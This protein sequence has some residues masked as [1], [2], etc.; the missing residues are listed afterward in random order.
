M[1]VVKCLNVDTVLKFVIIDNEGLLR[2]YRN[3]LFIG[4]WCWKI[5]VCPNSVLISQADSSVLNASGS[6][7]H[8]LALDLASKLVGDSYCVVLDPDCVVLTTN[9]I[10]KL[11]QALELGNYELIGIPQPISSNNRHLLQTPAKYKFFA[12]LALF[13]FGTTSVI[14][15]HSFKPLAEN[16]AQL[17]V[18]HS[19]ATQCLNGSVKYLLGSAHSTR[20]S[21]STI[22]FINDYHCSFH[23]ITAIRSSVFL[24]HFGRSS[25]ARSRR[26]SSDSLFLQIKQV[27]FDPILFRRKTK[28]YVRGIMV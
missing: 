12:P 11:S 7:Q 25:R 14:F 17:D 18:G 26:N 21:K 20:E 22:P 9:W 27:L 13:L 28:N 8:G 10:K 5:G 15:R 16:S 6:E 24:V 4:I 3:K 2:H 23:S 1:E 19:L